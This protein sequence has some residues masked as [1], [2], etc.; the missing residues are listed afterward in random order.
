MSND[1]V[2]RQRRR[3]GAAALGAAT[4]AVSVGLGSPAS[5]A[6]PAVTAAPQVESTFAVDEPTCTLTGSDVVSATVVTVP[7][8]GTKS[9]KK[10]ASGSASAVNTGDPSDTVAMKASNTVK[11]S[12]TG[13]GGGFASM[14]ATFTQSAKVTE[15]LGLFSACDPQVVTG[16]V[17]Q[18]VAHVVKAGKITLSITVPK[19]G[20]GEVILDGSDGSGGIVV[21]YLRTG[22]HTM[23][24]VVQ[25]GDYQIIAVLQTSAA[26]DPPFYQL[27]VSGTSTF[28]ATYKK[29]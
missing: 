26:L 13:K 25:P 27:D 28:K 17:V 3:R 19:Y 10:S 6:T 29:S 15:A 1:N 7:T 16:G 20:L 8:S 18:A 11:G 9:F 21:D 14:A 2:R 24:H 23:T 4:L 5:A 22:T 12:V